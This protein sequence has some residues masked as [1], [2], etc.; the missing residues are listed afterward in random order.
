MAGL[1]PPAGPKPLR[2]RRRDKPG[3]DGWGC[4]FRASPP[5]VVV[6]PG[7]RLA[8]A[9][10]T[11]ERVLLTRFCTPNRSPSAT[12][13]I[14]GALG[15]RRFPATKSAILTILWHCG[16]GQLS[17]RRLLRS[18][19]R[20]ESVNAFGR[21]FPGSRA[22]SAKVGTGFAFDRVQN[23]NWRMI[24]SPNRSYFGGSCARVW[25]C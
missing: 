16:Y 8:F 7:L 1:V 12:G 23:V 22:R 5:S 13:R 25:Q 17:F 15:G 11:E 2:P 19:C 20:Q 21:R 9:G 24:L 18:G 14:S 10:T 3:H 4:Y 6:G